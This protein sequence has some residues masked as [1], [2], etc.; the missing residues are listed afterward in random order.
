[1]K[2]P[3][4]DYTKRQRIN[5]KHD[6]IKNYFGKNGMP[7]LSVY[8]RIV[9]ESLHPGEIVN[10]YFDGMYF[11]SYNLICCIPEYFYFDFTIMS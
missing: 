11:S 10:H 8:R 6:R 4:M 9:T 1:M 7:K 2:V 5:I 3:A